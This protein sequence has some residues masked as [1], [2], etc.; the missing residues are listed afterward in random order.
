MAKAL[1]VEEPC[2]YDRLTRLGLE[3]DYDLGHLAHRLSVVH[4]Y[5]AYL[6]K[7]LG[8][9]N[10]FLFHQKPLGLFYYFSRLDCVFKVLVFLPQLVELPEPRHREFHRRTKLSSDRL[11]EITHDPGLNRPFYRLL[12]LGARYKKNRR[13]TNAVYLSGG[14]YAVPA[15]QSYVHDYDIGF[16][17][18]AGL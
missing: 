2:R 8:L 10:L 5:P 1:P 14:L 9:G 6:G 4:A 18:A 13:G 16:G 7:G 17:F 12:V 3:G 15:R 11:Y